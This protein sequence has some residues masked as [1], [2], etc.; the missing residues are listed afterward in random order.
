MT[1]KLVFFDRPN[2]IQSAGSALRR[3][4]S[5]VDRGFGEPDRGQYAQREEVFAACG[6]AVLF[7]RRALD[8]VGLLDETFFLYYEDTDL[9]WRMRL[10]GWRILYE[11]TAVVEHVHTGTNVEWSPLFTFHA[12]RNRLFMIVKNAPCTFAL[13]AFA[14]LS[15]RAIVTRRP[16]NGELAVGGAA[17]RSP[18]ELRMVIRIAVSFLAHLPEMLLKR[19]VIRRGRKIDDDSLLVW[20]T[21]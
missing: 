15:W 2:V 12:H 16:S 18:V 9:S 11:P 7:D 6:G 21:R 10:R 4:G 13:R 3:D 17:Q 20:S 8:D 5:G 1:S 19:M 14:S